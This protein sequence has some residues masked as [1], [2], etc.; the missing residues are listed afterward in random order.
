MIV[1]RL[2]RNL[3]L[4]AWVALAALPSL[5]QSESA[6]ETDWDGHLVWVL[7]FENNS[8]Q[9]GLDWIG[10]SFPDILNARLSSAGFLTIRR[11]DRRYAMRHLGLPADFHP[12]Q[13]TS[14]RIAQTLDADYVVF[15]SYTVANGRIQATARV[16]EMHGPSMGATLEEEG[17]LDQLIDIEDDLAWKTAMQIDPKLNLEEPTFLAASRDLRL[18]AFE[19]YIRGLV[20]PGIEE[21]IGHLTKAVQLSPGYVQAWFALG[22]AYFDNQQYDQAEASFAKVPKGGR[23]SLEAMFY[24]GLS[25]LYTGNYAGA[26]TT[27][28]AIASVLPLP[29]V[30]NNEGIAFN[31]RGQNGTAFFK[32]VVEMD[33]QSADYWFNL[34]VSERRQK[35]YTAALNAVAH[36][37]SL[38]PQDEEAQN[39]RKNLT[40]LKSG[41]LIVPPAKPAASETQAST[42]QNV[43]DNADDQADPT[44]VAKDKP[45]TTSTQ[46]ASGP[47]S[48]PAVSDATS[49]DYEPLERIAR[50]YDES[51]LR[52]GAFALEQMNAMKLRS[53]PPAKRAQRL[54]QQGTTYVNDGLLLEAERQFQLALAADPSSAAAY[55]GLAEVHEYAGSMKIAQQ[56]ANKSLQAKPNA[57]AYLVLARIALSQHDLTGARSNIDNALHLEPNNTAAKG[58][59]Q[60][61]QAQQGQQQ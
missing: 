39:L 33:P 22:L 25:D 23:L 30:L 60:A 38:H 7:P 42:N 36:A 27:F 61:I 56:E 34:A 6:N 45:D 19:N 2:W 52:Q 15:G 31:R 58:I 55:A 21:Q 16:L 12:T 53:M 57:A 48:A 26:Q 46:S 9:P 3:I 54:C 4:C 18:D 47:S 59:L 8:T 35:N 11:E 5:A 14:Y 24:S 44:S 37:L 32:R 20:E 13:A 40:M 51:S 43:V 17:N 41:Q 10:A 28:A 29:E 49:A 50:T 1:L